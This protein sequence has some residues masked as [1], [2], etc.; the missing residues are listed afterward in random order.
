[1]SLNKLFWS[2]H[3]TD[4]NFGDMLGP[5][6]FEKITGKSPIYSSLS[7]DEPKYITVGSILN[8]GYD[9]SIIW[10]SGV[11]DSNCIINGKDATYTAVRGPRSA[12]CLRNSGITPPSVYGDPCLLM[13]RF[14][15]PSIDKKYKLGII[16]H[17]IHLDKLK[18]TTIK[19]V[20]IIN[21]NDPIE[22]VIKNVLACE[23][24]I[25]GSLHGL[26]VSDAYGIPN[27]WVDFGAGLCGDGVK[28]IDHFE[29]V[30]RP[31][32]PP[33]D[34][35]NGKSFNM[36]QIINNMPEHINNIDLDALMN[37]CP[38]MPRI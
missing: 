28:F 24:I 13:P 23:Y 35:R 11:I 34:L 21:L 30:G 7:N 5:Y 12:Q 19:D 17:I 29:A 18:N 37:A 25:S 20:N 8:C 1:M 16:P 33:L 10:G 26:I 6:L 14:F 36:N 31:T 32:D 3:G 38:F 4:T 9:S 22:D 27:R 2:C 15:N